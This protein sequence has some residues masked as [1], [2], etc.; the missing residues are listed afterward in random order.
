M[1]SLSS[2]N[3]DA[4]HVAA[5]FNT[6]GNNIIKGT[7]RAKTITYGGLDADSMS[8]TA[9]GTLARHELTMAV[10]GKKE[11][12]TT[13]FN[14]G[15]AKKM[16]QGMCTQM[17]VTDH[18]LGPFALAKPVPL[19]VSR[20]RFTIDPFVL[21][22]T[23]RE[24]LRFEVDLGLTP[25]S[26]YVKGRWQ[27]LS[28]ARFQSLFTAA[29][30]AGKMSGSATV[31]WPVG[32]TL[33][34]AAETAFSDIALKGTSLLRIPKG[35]AK[36]K[37]DKSGLSASWETMLGDKGK[38]KGDAWSKEASSFSIPKDIHFQ[39]VWKDVDAAM[40]KSFLPDTLN[41]K[42]S[43]SGKANGLLLPEARFEIEGTAKL[44]EGY[45]AWKNTKG[46]TG[47][48]SENVDLDIGWKEE[49]AKGALS[50]T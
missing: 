37:W 6:D 33:Y 44:H 43:L 15:Y 20:E 40:F 50:L 46:E 21:T 28:I 32:Q 30:Y 39:T 35:D 25:K 18:L 42:G 26:G 19:K 36:I 41:L 23:G 2:A 8:L 48:K 3:M 7:M 10:N 34:I 45:L 38:L 11:K 47:I 22:G 31:E 13:V 16:W 49:T 1:L 29:P 5:Q 27:D 9:D 17:H 4:V 12:I 14:G 24:E